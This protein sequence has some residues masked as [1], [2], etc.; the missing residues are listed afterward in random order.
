MVATLIRL[1]FILLWNSL[2]RS[3]WQ[4]AAAAIGAVYGL[5]ILVGVVAGLFGLSFAPVEVAGAIV[6]LAGA[7]LI[8]GWTILPVLTSGIDQTVEPARL[9]PF[10]IPLPKLLVGLAVSGVLGVPGIVTS[11][12]ALST[13]VTWWRHPAAAAAAIVCAVIGVLTCVV[14]SRM[15]VALTSIIGEGR[16]FRE[17]KGL[18][19]FVPLILLGPIL[20]GLQ[21]LLSD[22]FDALPQIASIVAWTPLGAIWAVPAD[23]A[24]GDLG[25]AGLQFLIGLATLAVFALV[26]RWSLAKALETPA[27]STQAKAANRGAGFFGVFPGTPAGA[28]A[29]RALTYWIRDPRYAQSLIMLPLVPV[30]VLFYAGTN[31]DL[32]PL[33][34]VGPIIAVLL[35]MSIYTDVSYDSTAFAL[36]LQMGV[37]GRDDRI[38]RVLALAAFAVPVSLLTVV[39]TV[40]LTHAWSALPGLLGITI[41]V[42][43]SGF[44]LSSLISGRFVFAVPAP[45]ESPFKSKP[46]GG[47]SLTLSLFITW[48]ALAI[49]VLPELVIAIIG[50]ASGEM[51]FGWISLALGVLLGTVVLI[52]GVRVGGDILDRRG[53]ELLAELQRQ[54]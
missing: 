7:V 54:G 1:R 33:N 19:V 32:A 3:P 29:A 34:S 52:V 47:L 24:S 43:L 20:L 12:A 44:G 41:G 14:G 30:F 13:A 18:V 8:L 11:I 5:G 39:G 49:L 15:L 37:R 40:W 4:L 16:R 23:V 17:A 2:R 51:L 42:L 22:N 10:P 46:G 26:W 45:G 31:G 21:R 25:R 53:P 35:A 28:V 36:H 50:F 27:R 48:T 6:V 38:G 9:V